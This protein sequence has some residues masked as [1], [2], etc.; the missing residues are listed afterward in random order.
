MN[1]TVLVGALLFVAVFLVA[2]PSITGLFTAHEETVKIGYRPF[3]MAL[4]LY[5]A[6]EE[7][8]FVQEGIDVE[9]IKFEGPTNLL[10]AVASNAVQATANNA[11]L[12]TA[13][14][15]QR[16]DSFMLYAAQLDTYFH[17]ISFII[18]RKEI[19]NLSQVK[20]MGREPGNSFSSAVVEKIYKKR[21][22]SVPE[23]IDVQPQFQLQVLEAGDID[24]LLAFDP[25][26][27]IA[28][29]KGIAHI[30]LEAP[31]VEVMGDPTVGGPFL[32]SS[33]FIKKQPNKAKSLV[34]A[35]DRAIDFVRA[36][37]TLARSYLPKYVSVS[38]ELAELVKLPDYWKSNE[39]ETEIIQGQLDFL[40][41]S[42]FLDA[43]VNVTNKVLQ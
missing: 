8:F 15:M 6:L 18:A 9:L 5:V 28:V 29:Q 4:P 27:T 24:A 41:G 17:P 40:F 14:A 35:I 12:S 42:N 37:E 13:A 38:P 36:N 25:F 10:N 2:S 34:R 22:L 43:K 11:L 30:L 21:G 31:Q 33:E 32:I 39:L 23:F 26:T 16:T 1:K 19:E 20:R 3:T 7:G